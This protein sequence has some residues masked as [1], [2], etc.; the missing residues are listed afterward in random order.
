[1]AKKTAV[2]PGSFDP[3]T[4]GHTDIILRGLEV[5]D[6]IIVA[7]GINANKSYMFE[8]NKREEW[9]KNVFKNNPRIH[10][11]TYTGLTVNFCRS[12]GA[13]FILRG[14]RSVTDMEFEKTISVMNRK[15]DNEIE[16]VF[17]FSDPVFAAISS[18][19]VR[20][21]IKNGGD[22][23]MFIPSEIKIN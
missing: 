23:S 10:V 16:T 9:L 8:I 20:D 17:L 6:E 21:I 19:I 1:M 13:G 11:K 12:V 18:T 4:K 5:F 7:I 14:I 2:F 3:V 15:I 22:A